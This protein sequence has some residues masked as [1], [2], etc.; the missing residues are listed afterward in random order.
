MG[1]SFEQEYMCEFMDFGS[2]AFD[3]S[4]VERALDELEEAWEFE[5]IWRG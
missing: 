4:V 1:A 3:R 2:G 5:P